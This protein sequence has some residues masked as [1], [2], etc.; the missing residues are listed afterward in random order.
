MA[1]VTP[2]SEQY[3]HFVQDLQESFWGDLEARTQRAAQRLFD[4]LSAA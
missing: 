3:Q 1:K 2:I 4:E